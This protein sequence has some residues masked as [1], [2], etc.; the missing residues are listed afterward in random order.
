MEPGKYLPLQKE[1]NQNNKTSATNIDLGSPSPEVQGRPCARLV[2]GRLCGALVLV[3]L[4]PLLCGAFSEVK[5]EF[6][7]RRGWGLAG[8]AGDMDNIHHEN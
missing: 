5:V 4:L 2:L 7:G 1:Q 6:S 3:L 8:Y